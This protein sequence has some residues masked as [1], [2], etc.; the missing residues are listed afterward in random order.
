MELKLKTALVLIVVITALLL[1]GCGGITGKV[2][3]KLDDDKISSGKTTALKVTARNTGSKVFTGELVF[4]V[5]DSN[6][7]S[8]SYPDPSLLKFTLQP[9][10]SITRIV[11]VTGYSDVTRSDYKI[12]VRLKS[13]E[14]IIGKDEVTLTVKR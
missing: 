6:S 14:K 3:A 13:G 2:T 8:L 9:G 11:S 4:Q 10:E 5:E 7:V 12:W 1:T